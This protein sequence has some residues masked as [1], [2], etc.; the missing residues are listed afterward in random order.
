MTSDDVSIPSYEDEEPLPVDVTEDSVTPTPSPTGVEDQRHE[1]HDHDYDQ[2][3]Q[4]QQK[5][6][7]LLDD[8]Q[9]SASAGSRVLDAIAGMV[10]MLDRPLQAVVSAVSV[11]IS[12]YSNWNKT[13]FYILF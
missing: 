3:S 13:S 10:A 4:H 2:Q 8:H 1:D 11:T 12:S 9:H 6:E 7:A 5:G